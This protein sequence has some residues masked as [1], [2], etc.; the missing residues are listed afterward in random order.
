M[1]LSEAP[2]GVLLRIQIQGLKP[3]LHGLKFHDKADDHLT[4]LIGG[5]GSRV[6]WVETK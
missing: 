1:V 6:A 5:A 2:K 3:G 4:Q